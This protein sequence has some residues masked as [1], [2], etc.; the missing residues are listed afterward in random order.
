MCRLPNSQAVQIDNLAD[1][2][3]RMIGRKAAVIARMPILRSHDEIELLL[4]TVHQRDDR[5]TLPHRQ[6]AAGAEVVLKIDKD[7]G[8]HD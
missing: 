1:F 5:I 7:Q 6:R 3:T 2:F 4:Q 8:G